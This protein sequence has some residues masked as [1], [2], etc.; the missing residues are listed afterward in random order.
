SLMKCVEVNWMAILTGPEATGKTSLVRL[1]AKLTGN[2]LEEFSMN[3]SVDTTELLGGFEQLELSRH[4]QMVIDELISISNRTS[5]LLLIKNRN[6]IDEA[7]NVQLP[8]DLQISQVITQLCHFT[9]TL[10]NHQ[11]FNDDSFSQVNSSIMDF[12]LVNQLLTILDRTIRDFDLPLKDTLQH[13][14]EE[15]VKLKFM[16]SEVTAGCFEWIDGVLINAL[17]NGNWLLIDNANLCSPSVL[18]RLNPLLE[19]NGFLMV[20]EKGMTD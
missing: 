6:S 12:G 4:R 2:K 14:T 5:K 10:K 8:D 18:D 16:E 15:I 17:L 20:N 3:S 9:F 7:R 11:K 13:L 1:L 19:P